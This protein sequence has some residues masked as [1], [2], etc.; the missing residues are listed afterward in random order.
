MGDDKGLKS[1]A[2]AA[3]AVGSLAAI[4]LVSLAVVTGFKDT[5]LVDNDT[6]DN[7][8]TGLGIFGSFASVIV[9]ALVGKIVIAL[10]KKTG[11]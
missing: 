7:F 4:T 2:V 1:M 8:I 10:F 9:L 6:A 11:D 3:I 5:D